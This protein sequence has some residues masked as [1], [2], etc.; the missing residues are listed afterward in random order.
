MRVHLY[1]IGSTFQKRE[2]KKK[3]GV[4]A[5]LVFLLARTPNATWTLSIIGSHRIFAYLQG[6]KKDQGKE[7]K[8]ERPSP[9]RRFRPRRSRPATF[10][11]PAHLVQSSRSRP[12]GRAGRSPKS[13]LLWLRHRVLPLSLSLHQ[14]SAHRA[15]RGG[16][17]RLDRRKRHTRGHWARGEASL[18]LPSQSRIS[19]GRQTPPPLTS[20]RGPGGHERSR[21]APVVWTWPPGRSRFLARRREEVVHES[22]T[23]G[24]TEKFAGYYNK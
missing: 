14:A 16:P 2:K 12:H 20:R 18:S 3:P 4:I 10:A 1:C 15:V 19:P 5:L 7:G 8:S 23:S 17:Q 22:R 11:G 24:I 13:K 6:W 21:A 9:V